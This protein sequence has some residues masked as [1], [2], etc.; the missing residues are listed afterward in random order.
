M[1]CVSPKLCPL[2]N[3]FITVQLSRFVRTTPVSLYL[4]TSS[5]TVQYNIESLEFPS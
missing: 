3:V 5:V 1:Q 4:L 2:T